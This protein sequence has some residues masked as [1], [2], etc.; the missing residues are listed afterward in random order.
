MYYFKF[1]I[2]VLIA[3][4]GFYCMSTRNNLV[5]DFTDHDLVKNAYDAVFRTGLVS[6]DDE[7]ETH[8]MSATGVYSNRSKMVYPDEHVI[9]DSKLELDNVHP[10]HYTSTPSYNDLESSMNK[11]PPL[12]VST[13]IRY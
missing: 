5:S 4:V 3:L 1:L 9:L 10:T 11:K 8:S 6:D 7:I 2:I 13:S 12:P